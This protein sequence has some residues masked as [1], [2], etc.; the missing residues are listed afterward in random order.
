M[1]IANQEA[2]QA[3]VAL[4]EA[5]AALKKVKEV[6]KRVKK[7]LEMKQEVAGAMKALYEEM[8]EEADVGLERD[9]RGEGANEA[10]VTDTSQSHE[11]TEVQP[12]N[13]PHKKHQRTK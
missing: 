5:E 1:D 4:N 2:K 12:V 7:S 6:L 9:E 13:T 10:S 11:V 3:K 8:A